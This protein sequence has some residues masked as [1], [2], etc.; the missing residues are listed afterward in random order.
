M[1]EEEKTVA[2]AEMQAMKEAFK[3]KVVYCVCC[4]D[5][6]IQDL[7][8]SNA[9]ESGEA[10][11]TAELAISK[12]LAAVDGSDPSKSNP[13]SGPA[14]LSLASALAIA[15]FIGTSMTL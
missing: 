11:S 3:E 13:A 6:T 12:A 1:S 14:S 15:A 8:A 7:L 4:Q 5:M 9:D 10:V 2:K